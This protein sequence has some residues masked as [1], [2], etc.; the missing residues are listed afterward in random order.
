M[1]SAA[2]VTPARMSPA[3]L[4][5]S[6]GSTP[7]RSGSEWPFILSAPRLPDLDR[8]FATYPL[9]DVRFGSK[10][11]I[12]ECETNVRFGSKAHISACPRNVR[13][14][15]ES[16]HS[17]SVSGCPLRPAAN[18]GFPYGR[19]PAAARHSARAEKEHTPYGAHD[20][21]YRCCEPDRQL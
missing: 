14:T 19:P 3:S 6:S 15:P 16:G 10:A 13:F 17:L 8:F 11:D 18:Q 20:S 4:L 7:R 12:A 9:T 5:V 21:R 1:P 2:S